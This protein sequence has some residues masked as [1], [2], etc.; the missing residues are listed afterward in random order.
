MV[1]I[2]GRLAEIMALGISFSS[3]V[4]SISWLAI[5]CPKERPNLGM[6][7]WTTSGKKPRRVA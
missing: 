1:V 6:A 3:Q 7:R 4:K 2:N 5:A